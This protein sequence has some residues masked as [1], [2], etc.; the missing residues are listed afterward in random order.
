MSLNVIR[1]YYLLQRWTRLV[2]YEDKVRILMLRMSLGDIVPEQHMHLGAGV[3]LT[4]GSGYKH[5]HITQWRRICDE[6]IAPTGI[7]LKLT[8]DDWKSVV[9]AKH[10]M[11]IHLPKFDIP[12]TFKQGPDQPLVLCHEC[13]PFGPYNHPMMMK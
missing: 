11:R 12:A 2:A 7:G 13:S 5:I 3:Y 4:L 10:N 6:N 9:E 8:S 1:S